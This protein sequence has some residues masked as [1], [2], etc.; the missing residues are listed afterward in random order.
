[1]RKALSAALAMSVVLAVVSC[2]RTVEGNVLAAP[3]LT[4]PRLGAQ[5][6]KQVLLDD[7]A[8]SELLGQKMV[9]REALESGG[10][11]QLF[12]AKASISPAGCAGTV[13]FLQK[14]VYRS[15]DVTAFAAQS[16]FLGAA[17]KVMFVAEGVVALP[18]AGR[19]DSLFGTFAEQWQKC[20]G[21]SAAETGGPG[22]T[23]DAI[24]EVHTFDDV[25][26]AIN[27]QTM[28]FPNLPAL[29][30][31][32]QSRA[33]GVGVNCIVEAQVVL[34]TGSHASDPGTADVETIGAEL[35]RAIQKNIADRS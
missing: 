15:A 5:A 14:S 18:T 17:G 33:L 1:M 21:I 10:P 25:V 35:V 3:E 2:S 23:T 34:F 6:I 28:S 30:P 4:R 7:D 22:T 11:E 20:D 8:L 19:A 13:Q 16:W 32:R 12:D 29:R 31:T 9:K 26:S 24:S 27:T